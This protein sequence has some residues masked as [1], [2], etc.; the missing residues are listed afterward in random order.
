MAKVEQKKW[1]A[2]MVSASAM[3][4]M[5]AEEF[6]AWRRKYD[7]PRIV[8]Y[9]KEQQP[10]FDKWMEDQGVTDDLLIR[11]SPSSFLSEQAFFY[12]YTL[13]ENETTEKEISHIYRYDVGQKVFNNSIVK[14]RKD[15]IPY[16][17]WRRQRINKKVFLPSMTS[18]TGRSVYLGG[19]ELVDI[20][21]CQVSNIF[22]GNRLLDF[23]NV[24]DL[25]IINC[26]NNSMIKLWFCMATNITITG[27]LHFVDG[28][29]STFY[30]NMPV[31]FLNLKLLNGD[32]QR[33]SFVNCEVNITATNA[34]INRWQFIGWDFNATL[35]NT[36]IRDCTFKSSRISAPIDYG[37]AKVFH[38]HLKRLYSQLNQKKKASEHYYLEKNFER[39]S[40][41][42]LRPNYHDIYYGARTPRAKKMLQ[43]RYFFKFLGS[44]FLNILWGYGERPARVFIISTF[45]ILFFAGCYCFVPGA[46]VKTFH[47]FGNA[48]YY[49]MVTFTTLGYGDIS[50]TKE[51]LK[52]MSGLEAILG[53]TFWGILIAGFT[54]NAKDY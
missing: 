4:Q 31:K 30:D 19:L 14:A 27:D 22:I 51:F 10:E 17:T 15:I 44:G 43:V 47:Q 1:P 13:I 18:R 40:Y 39:K 38:A 23:T 33:W 46:S 16:T 36:E 32:Y 49:S 7:Y 54:S 34:I 45:S 8:S 42:H 53:M 12:L 28:F 29:E 21:A 48:L 11:F 52:L 24:S 6:N 26:Y 37:R 50:Q 25:R 2:P 5:S 9:L 41:L 35:S 20:G 3:W